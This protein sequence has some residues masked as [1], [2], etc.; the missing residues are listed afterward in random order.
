MTNIAS[1][2]LCAGKGRRM[3]ARR[4]PKVCFPVAGKPAVLHLLEH[5]DALGVAPNIM[6]VGHLAGKVVEEIGPKSPRALFAYQAELKGTGHATKQGAAL[7]QRVN[8]D[9]AILVVAGDKVVERRALEKLLQ[10]YDREQPDIALLVAPKNRWPNAGRIVCDEKGGVARI[11]ERADLVNAEA[12]SESFPLNGS[13]RSAAEIESAATTVNQAVYLFRASALFDSLD[14]LSTGNVQKEEYLTDTIEHVV[15]RGGR[16]IPV[17]VD[18]PNDVLA[19]NNPEE[20]LAIEEYFRQKSGIETATG[21]ALDPRIFKTPKEWAARLQSP[22]S[23]MNVLLRA[24]YGESQ[25]L[26]E[27]KRKRLLAAVELFIK[28]FGT[29]GLVTVIRAP[30]RINLMGRHVD[31][32][33]G[34]VNL[35]AID[36]EHILVARPRNDATVVARNA[37]AGHFADLEFSVG[38]LLA[39]VGLDDWREF[40]NSRIVM[41]LVRDLAGDWGNYLKAPMLRLQQQFKERLIYGVDCVVSGD[42]P[43]AAGLSSSSALVVAMADALVLTNGLPLTAHDLVDVCGEGEWFVGTRGG[44]ADHAAVKLSQARRVAHVGF[45]PF[46]IKEYVPFPDGYS[47]VICNSRIQ[48]RKAAGAR[49]IFNERVASYEFAVLWVKDRFP[50]Y[51]PLITH[52]RD[53]SAE[54][55]G[56]DEAGIY[57]ILL[58]VPERISPQA[59]KEKFGADTFASL[60]QSHTPPVE[61]EL[62]GRLL[63]GIAECERSKRALELLKLADLTEFGRMMNISHDGDRVVTANRTAFAQDIE[64]MALQML[65]MDLS[66]E[67]SA[68]LARLYR[69]PGVYACSIPEIDAMVEIALA[70]PGVLGAQLS[71]AG[72]GGCMMA[73]VEQ[74]AASAVIENMTQRYYAPNDLKPGA[75]EFSPV[76]GSGPLSL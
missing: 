7:L 13:Q 32:R 65:T 3:Q 52:L 58:E 57:T 51:A 14:A 67:E 19:F 15:K 5:L 54:N 47:L 37:D 10:T 11:I 12:K 40:V 28:R 38:D 48:A 16:V 1:I 44:S 68:D 2:I 33:G 73:L 25:S 24:L 29:D 26:R 42:I 9:G 55:L 66:S 20:L 36:R 18:H 70:T 71:G 35:M 69:Q 45:F 34:C 76:A 59:L 63:F 61:Y 8:F 75:F 41:Q 27:E 43:I 62:R 22:D 17:P 64:N 53:I 6:V 30:G 60:T 50:N 39:Q 23:E 56:V 4:T 74:T 46:A 49:D 31:H 72:L 21:R